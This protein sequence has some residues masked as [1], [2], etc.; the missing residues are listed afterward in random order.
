MSKKVK[1]RKQLLEEIRILKQR[2]KRE[3]A[4]GSF[5]VHIRMGDPYNGVYKKEFYESI[6][7]M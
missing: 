6:G 3:K 5:M 1:S 7:R 2:L 4:F